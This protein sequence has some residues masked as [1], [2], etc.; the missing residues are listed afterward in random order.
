[1]KKVLFLTTMI[2]LIISAVGPPSWGLTSE[3][4]IPLAISESIL[5]SN[6][7][8]GDP[9]QF[10]VEDW[11]DGFLGAGN[12]LVVRIEAS[13]PY[14]PDLVSRLAGLMPAAEVDIG[15][16]LPLETG[17][18][19]E[20]TYEG[21]IGKLNPAGSI[22][23]GGRLLLETN[24]LY[25]P[26]EEYVTTGY[27]PAAWQNW[28]DS[29]DPAT[30]QHDATRRLA[31]MPLIGENYDTNGIEP[32]TVSGFAEFF[33]ERVYDGRT[34]DDAGVIRPKGDIEGRFV[35]ITL[36]EPIPEPSGL[37]A[38]ACGLGVIGGMLRRCRR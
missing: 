29:Y 22:I 19:L 38:L 7:Q 24:P 12:W 11:Q 13:D 33:I 3:K 31:I 20:K 34:R 14:I 25:A 18:T 36:G 30:G 10:T 27:N 32:V 23:N 9:W 6:P 21:L 15:E 2:A 16:E 35:W 28:L 37:V 17:M 1:M 4:I 8:P 5:D 26:L